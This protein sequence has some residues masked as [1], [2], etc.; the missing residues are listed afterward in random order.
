MPR[1]RNARSSSSGERCRQKFTRRRARER[2][3]AQGARRDRANSRYEKNAVPRRSSECC[4][5]RLEGEE[6]RRGGVACEVRVEPQREDD[7]LRVAARPIATQTD[8][9]YV[10]VRAR[11]P[12]FCED[13]RWLARR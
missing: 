11:N 7:Q 5:G 10:N 8:T 12:H 4:R 3:R 9:R 6:R 1:P 13:S 2:S